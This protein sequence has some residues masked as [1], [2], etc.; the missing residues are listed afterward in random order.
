MFYKIYNHL[1]IIG[2]KNGMDGRYACIRKENT[3]CNFF[4]PH[5]VSDARITKS[6]MIS[7]SV[8]GIF[9]IMC[10]IVLTID[11][12][13]FSD[14]DDVK[15]QTLQKSLRKK[16]VSSATMTKLEFPA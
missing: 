14:I 9:C 7:L 10:L 1:D 6:I 5:I 8:T 11:K 13:C 3:K 2:V 16:N 12:Y 4:I 15:A